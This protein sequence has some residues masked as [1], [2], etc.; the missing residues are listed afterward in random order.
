M[1]PGALDSTDPS[2]WHRSLLLAGA[3]AAFAVVGA[4]VL[5]IAVGS[6]T[7]S[8]LQALSHTAAERFVEL[9][10][11]PWLG[12]YRLDLLN[13]LVQVVTIPVYV[14]MAYAHA[15][16]GRPLAMLATA[17]FLVAAAL[18]LASNA[19]L[20][21]LQLACDYAASGS[22]VERAS[23]AAAGEGLLARGAH[24]S[25]G[26]F[27]A[28]A[29]VSVAGLLMS[30]AMLQELAFSRLTAWAG[31]LGNAFLLTYLVVVTFVPAAGRFAMA[32]AMPGG[33]L[34]LA[35]LLL[36]GLRL[37]RRARASPGAMA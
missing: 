35:W 4:I 18:F 36:V 3:V 28:F 2:G 25:L 10:R 32:L 27:P 24:G 22:L 14:A 37:L 20:A 31:L 6:T 16:R 23:L 7:G 30:L 17:L 21:M 8:D 11:S 13:A 19:A 33:L 34:A 5:D 29:L 26:V 9:Q 15:G 1:V 12:L